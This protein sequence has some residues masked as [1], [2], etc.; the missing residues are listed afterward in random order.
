METPMQEQINIIDNLLLKIPIDKI[1]VRNQLMIAK[2][3]AIELLQKEKE[4]IIEAY[5]NGYEVGVMQDKVTTGEQYY[6]STF[7]IF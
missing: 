1:G 4:V 3:N 7:E 6:Y 2:N 5:T